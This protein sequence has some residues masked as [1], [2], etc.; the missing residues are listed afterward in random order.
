MQVRK[1]KYKCLVLDHDDTVVN[2][3]ATINYPAFMNVLKHLRP[4]FNLTLDEYIRYNFE[5]G[6]NSL[7]RDMLH[8]TDQEM[9]YQT[10]NWLKYVME[11][12]PPIFEGID[13]ILWRFHKEGGHICVVS[14]SMKENIVRDYNGNSLPTPD[15]IFGWDMLPEQRKPSI[16]PIGQILERLFLKPEELVMIDDLKPGKI[17]ADNAGIDFIGAGWAHSIP[18]ISSYMKRE[19]QHYCSSVSELEQYIF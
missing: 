13:K 12:T 17:M 18:E 9:Q 14:H 19:C 10:D 7:C 2:S 15:M 16:W 8:F 3:A 1:M 4:G 6:F 5:P 11:H